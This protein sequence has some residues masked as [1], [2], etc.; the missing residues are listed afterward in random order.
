M[1]EKRYADILQVIAF[2]LIFGFIL[3][4]ATKVPW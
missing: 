4:V 1:N 2:I 3:V